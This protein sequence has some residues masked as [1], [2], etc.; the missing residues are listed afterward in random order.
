MGGNNCVVGGGRV[1]GGARLEELGREL[2]E[3]CMHLWGKDVLG[4]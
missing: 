4:D 1:I 2:L 3:E